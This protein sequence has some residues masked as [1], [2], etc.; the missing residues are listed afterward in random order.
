MKKIIKFLSVGVM[1]LMLMPLTSLAGGLND[2]TSDM[3]IEEIDGTEEWISI[4]EEGFFDNQNIKGVI[5]SEKESMDIDTEFDFML[6]ECILNSH[7]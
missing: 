4:R 7:K 3:N 6:C 2:W 1:G 5:I